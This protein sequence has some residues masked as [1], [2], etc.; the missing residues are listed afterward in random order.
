MWARS[1]VRRATG[2]GSTLMFFWAGLMAATCPEVHD[3]SN[4]SIFISTI[5]VLH[6]LSPSMFVKYTMLR[7]RDWWWLNL[8]SIS[9]FVA[10]ALAASVLHLP[11]FSS[12]E[13]RALI[14]AIWMFAAV[15]VL[16]L[17]LLA[18]NRWLAGTGEPIPA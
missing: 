9:A 17:V 2:G 1:W 11:A 15:D 6:W 7:G 10:I 4:V 16:D 5:V 8:I 3:L 18:A 12:P 13:D 14:W